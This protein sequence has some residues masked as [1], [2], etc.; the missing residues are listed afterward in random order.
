MAISLPKGTHDVILDDAKQY[1]YVETV[2]K[3]VAEIYGYNEMRTPIFEHTE[4]FQRSAGDSSDVVRKEMYTFLDKGDRS[5]T[6]RPE[7]TAG[8]MRSIVQNK[9]YATVQDL[10]IKTWYLGPAFRYERPQAGRFRQF[11]QFGIESVGV[12]N[13]YH[14]AEV[15]MMGYSSL[16]MLG[17]KDVTIKINSLGDKASRDAYRTALKEYFKDK[18]DNMCSDC[19]QR[20]EINPLRI[21]DCKVP[22][23]QELCKGA[24]IMKDYLNEESKTYFQ[25]ILNIL[26]AYQIKYE[27][28]D[29]LVRG[30]DYYSH[31]V[32][33]FHYTSKNGVNLGAIGAGGHYDNLVKEVGGPDMPGVGLAMGIERVQSVLKDEGLLDTIKEEHDA[34]VMCLDEKA[35]PMAYELLIA[36]RTSGFRTDMLLEPKGFKQQ[37]KRAERKNSKLA[38]IIG[39]DELEKGVVIVRD[40]NA[41]K[42]FEVANKDVIPTVN[43]FFNSPHDHGCCCHHD[44]NEEHEC[45]C[46][47]EGHHHDS[48]EHECCC[49]NK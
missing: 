39:N 24:P 20:Y 18:I 44:D 6:L 42:Q 5:I 46:G 1:D 45:C 35:M 19:K 4:L 29:N 48:E 26:D 14:D 41:Q 33:E 38:L 8:I 2:L 40:L 32:F 21:L 11:N 49:K 27:I 15:I 16:L 36:L 3:N 43:S 13:F 28:D 22:E 23:D 31:V 12:S 17:L 47:G 30:L 7:L 34:S 25:N 10:P 37:F 9:L